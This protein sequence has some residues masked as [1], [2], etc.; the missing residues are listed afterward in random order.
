M[1]KD[2]KREIDLLRKDEKD[3]KKDIGCVMVSYYL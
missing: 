3:V 2:I 1:Y